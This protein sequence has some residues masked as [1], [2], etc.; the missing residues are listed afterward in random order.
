MPVAVSANSGPC[1][2]LLDYYQ[3]SGCIVINKYKLLNVND[4][5]SCKN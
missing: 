3:S 4:S 5:L 2:Y 1:A